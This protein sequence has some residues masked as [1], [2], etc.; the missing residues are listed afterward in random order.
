MRPLPIVPCACAA[1]CA[2][3]C[4]AARADDPP[5]AA[6]E[7]AV[8]LILNRNPNY[9][10]S[11]H[12]KWHA[13]PGVYLRYGRYSVTTTGGFV[14]RRNDQVE[15]GLTAD[16]VDRDDYR[17]S[18]SGRFDNG[19]DADTDPALAGLPDIRPTLRARL[20]A[21][22]R[23]GPGWRLGAGISPDL[24]NRGG[25]TL[26]DFSVGREW[27]ASP[28]V[29]TTV[30]LTLVAA[31]GRYMRSYFGITPAQSQTTGLRAFEPG[32]G[33]RDATLG[34]NW[35]IQLTPR[36]FALAGAGATRLLGDARHSPLT[37][38]ETALEVS[39]AL[40]WQF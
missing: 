18:L 3:F 37:H 39:G 8:G 28:S 23:Y 19:R 1:A 21:L 38:R 14:T 12:S 9:L 4:A 25:G 15:R 31:D 36:W 24:F 7:G 17:V 20:S 26:F 5:P 22:K 32:R 11:E 29:I 34:A 16:L 2:L 35:R 40:A 27:A 33:L 30:T 10:G 13:I 6:F